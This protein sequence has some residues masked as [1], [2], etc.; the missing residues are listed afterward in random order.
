LYEI[1]VGKNRT[2]IKVVR[3]KLRNNG[4]FAFD[5]WNAKTDKHIA[6]SGTK[7]FVKEIKE[8][9]HTTPN[10]T[11]TRSTKKGTSAALSIDK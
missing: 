7:R 8:P 3:I 6:I 4:Q 1:T 5:C 11:K 10:A 9:K 2:T